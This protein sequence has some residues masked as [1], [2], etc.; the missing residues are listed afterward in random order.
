VRSEGLSKMILTIANMLTVN[1]SYENLSSSKAFIQVLILMFCSMICTSQLCKYVTLLHHF[2]SSISEPI[3]WDIY[4]EL[5]K[6]FPLCN[7]FL[8]ISAIIN[9]HE[10]TSGSAFT[11]GMPVAMFQYPIKGKV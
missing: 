5:I 3:E 6:M 4:K 2:R 11:A 1:I 7:M 8:L 9:C 10:H